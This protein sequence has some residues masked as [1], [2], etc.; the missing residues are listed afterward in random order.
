MRRYLLLFVVVFATSISFSNESSKTGVTGVDI[1]ITP[2]LSKDDEVFYTLSPLSWDDFQGEPDS[3]SEWAAMTY[4]GI[5]LKYEYTEKGDSIR[6]TVQLYPYVDKKKSW[7]KPSGYNAYTLAHEQVHF[8]IAALVTHQLAQEIKKTD[9]NLVD[10]PL[11]IVKLHGQY[12][13]KLSAMQEAY[14]E[15]TA[16]GDNYAVQQEW[17]H[18]IA[19]EVSG[20]GVY[21]QAE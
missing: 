1:Q 2:D 9:F 13:K 4:S 3:T 5:R 7:V 20:Y 12:I 10:F 16:H 15:E 14:D 17:K 6:A 11:T 8:D 21:A 19:S 18:R